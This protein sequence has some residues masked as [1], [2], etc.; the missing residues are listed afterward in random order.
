MKKVML[1]VGYFYYV[2]KGYVC[3]DESKKRS[4]FGKWYK[5]YWW[6]L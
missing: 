6:K 4:R 2:L 1:F 3:I 5:L